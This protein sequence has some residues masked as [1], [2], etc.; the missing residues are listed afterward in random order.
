MRFCRAFDGRAISIWVT[1]R[2]SISQSLLECNRNVAAAIPE[3]NATT[4]T[5]GRQQIHLSRLRERAT[6]INAELAEPAEQMQPRKHE[7][8]KTRR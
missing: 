8:T 5:Q 1:Y 7:D 6:T 3:A 4:N 2:E